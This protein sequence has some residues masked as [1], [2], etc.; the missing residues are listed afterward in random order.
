M[1][2]YFKIIVSGSSVKGQA[3]ANRFRADKK[4][5]D[6]D[7][8]F[9]FGNVESADQI[10]RI[11][12][13]PGFV[14][15]KSVSKIYLPDFEISNDNGFVN[16][17][18]LKEKILLMSEKYLQ[19][20][21]LRSNSG[22]TSTAAHTASVELLPEFNFEHAPCSASKMLDY[23]E[24]LQRQ[25][26][27]EQKT[28]NFA[29]QVVTDTQI[30]I[31]TIVPLMRQA[32]PPILKDRDYYKDCYSFMSP[33]F[34]YRLP[35]FH[36]E[37]A[38]IILEFY[39]KYK[40]YAE[41]LF[42][43]KLKS[44]PLTNMDWVPALKL[45]FW[46]NDMHWFLNRLKQNRPLIYE[47]IKP[48]HM[49][50]ISKWSQKT[51][52]EFENLEFRY[53]FS[54]IENKLAELRTPLEQI[55]NR[56]ARGIF[57]RYLHKSAFAS[58]EEEYLTSYFVKTTVLWMCEIYNFDSIHSATTTYVH[59]TDQI[60]AERIGKRWIT[61]CAHYF[62]EHLNVLDGFS[63][64]Y[65]NN[66][67]KIL[68]NDVNLRDAR[69]PSPTEEEFYV[70]NELEDSEEL[71]DDIMAF[72]NHPEFR[73]D[74][75]SL[76]RKITGGSM[77]DDDLGTNFDLDSYLHLQ[78]C[79]PFL[80]MVVWDNPVLCNWQR[81]QKLFVDTPSQQLS[82]LFPEYDDDNDCPIQTNKTP[83]HFFQ[84]MTSFLKIKEMDERVTD[85][86]FPNNNQVTQNLPQLDFIDQLLPAFAITRYNLSEP[87]V[88]ESIGDTRNNGMITHDTKE[89][90]DETL[91]DVQKYMQHAVNLLYNDAPPIMSMFDEDPT[92]DFH[93]TK[94]S[95]EAPEGYTVVTEEIRADPQPASGWEARLDNSFPKR[96]FYM[97]HH[98]HHVTWEPPTIYHL[99]QRLQWYSYLKIT[100][101]LENPQNN[102]ILPQLIDLQS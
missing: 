12:N 88:S 44:V 11:S 89:D 2:E 96:I 5:Q 85:Q 83:F 33:A 54:L 25:L 95:D 93:F 37:K 26:P 29:H 42:S 99:A 22:V 97:D 79:L 18:K 15:L 46:P 45:K 101:N 77:P 65:L 86:S 64:T 60:V 70:E 69:Y 47:E 1:T 49:H 52:T 13:V 98:S 27:N 21:Y 53:S 35:R 63:N 76:A 17:F 4:L 10:V 50:L 41:K 78:V 59:Q 14:L 39:F 30:M 19:Q 80:G 28:N 81:W 55:L 3:S 75:K 74:C 23:T 6:V 57:Y 90:D 100:D 71:Y 16:G 82:V 40:K 56:V 38:E 7:F 24:A 67:Y 91:N 73:E 61:Y 32:A 34:G 66:I 62:I 84:L 72:T 102:V 94:M 31:E 48:L 20:A 92:Q 43:T 68:Q 87:L 9:E 8:M 36:R 51:P 58:G